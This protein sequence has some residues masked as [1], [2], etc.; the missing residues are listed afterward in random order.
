M[1][2]KNSKTNL[3]FIQNVKP[4]HAKDFI[5]T[6]AAFMDLGANSYM[7]KLLFQMLPT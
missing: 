3:I 4:D 7:K 5:Q 1:E 6:T 2:E